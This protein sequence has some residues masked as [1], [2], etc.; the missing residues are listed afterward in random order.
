MP[1]TAVQSTASTNNRPA[2]RCTVLMPVFNC[3]LYLAEAIQSILAQTYCDFHRFIT[4]CANTLKFLCRPKKNRASL[5]LIFTHAILRGR[6]CRINIFKTHQI[7]PLTWPCLPEQLP[8]RPGVKPP[9]FTVIA[10]QSKQRRTSA[11]SATL[12]ALA[13][14]RGGGKPTLTSAINR[15]YLHAMRGAA[16]RR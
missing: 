3:E 2:S 12:V 8:N 15:I 4:P 14:L 10:G 11:G 9:L 6:C 13:G 7:G 5:L 1:A 16:R